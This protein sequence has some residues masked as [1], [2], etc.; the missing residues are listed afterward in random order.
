MFNWFL[1]LIT[2]TDLLRWWTVVFFFELL[3]LLEL[4]VGERLRL[5]KKSFKV[6]KESALH[7]CV[8]CSS[9]SRHG[10]FGNPVGSLAPSQGHLWISL[11]VWVA[12]GLVQLDQIIAD[13][14]TLVG[15]KSIMVLRPDPGKQL[16]KRS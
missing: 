3:I 7:F 9:W 4:W 10:H 11:E 14:V 16:A 1:S 6:S 5:E 2:C 12:L 15:K 8:G 13:S